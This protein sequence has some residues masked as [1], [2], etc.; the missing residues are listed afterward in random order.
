MKN[1][2][3]RAAMDIYACILNV[4]M[5]QLCVTHILPGTTMHISYTLLCPIKIQGISGP[6]IVN[7]HYAQHVHLDV[8]HL[9]FRG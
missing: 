3:L 6:L 8:R 5:L 9:L 1:I 4:R 7:N 2:E